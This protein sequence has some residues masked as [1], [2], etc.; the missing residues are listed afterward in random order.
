MFNGMPKERTPGLKEFYL[1]SRHGK[2]KTTQ[3]QVPP[4]WRQSDNNLAR[5]NINGVL[6]AVDTL[7]ANIRIE[8]F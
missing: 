1:T 6:S 4:L 2:R 7:T 8:L 5:R 3:D